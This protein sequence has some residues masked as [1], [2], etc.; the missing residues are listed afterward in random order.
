MKIQTKL[1]F[2]FLAGSLILVTSMYGLMQWS[3]DKGMLD[4]INERDLSAQGALADSLGKL[5]AREGSWDFIRRN[6]RLWRELLQSHES[7]GE[8]EPDNGRRPP[9]QHRPPPR[10]SASTRGQGSG[11]RPP[12]PDAYGHLPP[13]DRRPAPPRPRIIL[14]D[15]GE[16]VLFG[17][18]D[19]Q[20]NTP[21]IEITANDQVVGWL[22]IPPRDN[23]SNAYDVGFVREQQTAF[24][25]ISGLLLLLSA[26][27]AYPLAIVLTRPIKQL[28][29]GTSQLTSGNYDYEIHH[30]SRDELGQLTQDFN[31]LARTLAA[32]E[33]ARKHWIADISHELRTPL[34]IC[35]GELEAMLEGVRPATTDTISSTHQE[36]LRLQRIVEDLYE[37]ANADIGALRYQFSD[38]DFTELVAHQVEKYQQQAG[39]RQIQLQCQLP[40][41]ELWVNGDETRLSQLINNLLSNSLKYTDSGGSVL[42]SLQRKNHNALLTIEDSSPGVTAADLEKLFDPLFRVESSRNRKTGGS[43]LGL[44]ICKKIVAGHNGKIQLSHAPAGGLK[45]IIELPLDD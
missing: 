44:A 31:R 3:F 26:C 39:E 32:N 28:A 11:T 30:H 29:K 35:R 5:Y 7:D 36:I 16:Q 8:L 17:P 42:L 14:L 2:A 18:P 34:T 43:G 23:L 12:R 38:L 4:Y 45:V 1:F 6:H 33:N 19:Y 37:L 41:R 27:I 10:P 40:G 15:E 21:R 13:P 9:G 22:T 20:Q 24:L 25:L